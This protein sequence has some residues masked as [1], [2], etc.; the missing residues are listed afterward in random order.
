MM[1]LHALPGVA[2]KTLFTIGPS[3]IRPI[4]PQ[5]I[6]GIAASSSMTI[7]NVSFTFP[8]ANSEM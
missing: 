7:F 6:E 3:T 4:N 5:T 2:V 8:W 1:W